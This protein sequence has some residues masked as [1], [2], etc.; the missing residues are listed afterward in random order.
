MRT[1]TIPGTDLSV[2]VISLGVADYGTRLNEADSF[3]RFDQYAVQG[4]NFYDTAHIYAA[5]I[6]GGWGEPE[7]VLGRWLKARGNR[8][9]AVIA[10]KGGHPHLESM[11][12]SRLSR[13]EILQDLDES[14]DRLQ[15]ECVDLYWLH[16]DE[17]ARPVADIA[18]T[19]QIAISAQ[20][21]RFFGVSNWSAARI[22]ELRDYLNAQN[23]AGF[24]GSQV[25]WSLAVR[26][27]NVGGDTTIRFMDAEMDALHRET[28]LFVAA[29]SSQ[30][31]GFFAGAYGRDIP[32][33][34]PRS[35]KSVVASYYSERNFRRL[36][37]A[38]ELAHRR[39]CHANSI[40]LAY[41]TS[42]PFP[43]SAIVSCPSER[44]LQ[45]T[46]EAGD[47]RLTEAEIAYLVS[48]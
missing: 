10:T 17:E 37:R 48:D 45:M 41:L 6:P 18:E 26:N 13:A 15:R 27:A 14:L 42:Q 40:A 3:A 36:E 23:L 7:R 19:L 16:R 44:A 33:P 11:H 31:N 28:G 32:N 12:V 1:L 47:V 43:V 25:G 2:S 29:Y 4:G 39:G 46:L 34:T 22:K 24:A 9:S 30:A 38:Q 5:W 8:E 20:K 35:A 21:I